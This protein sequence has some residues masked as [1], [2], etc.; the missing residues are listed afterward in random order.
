VNIGA[1]KAKLYLKASTNSIHAFQIYCPILV[2][3]GI[4]NLH[5]MLFS[6]CEFREHRRREGHALLMGVNEITFTVYCE[7]E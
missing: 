4:T 5:T 3:I 1:V 7:T 2:K 6:N